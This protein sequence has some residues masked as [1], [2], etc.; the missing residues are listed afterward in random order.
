ML[1]YKF[2]KETYL[3]DS[4]PEADFPRLAKRAGEQLSQYKR[5]YTVESPEEDS[6]SLATCAIADAMYYF[7]V[8][9]NGGIVT[10][11]S[12][13]SVS[14][15]QQAQTIDVSQKAQAKEFY[16]CARLYLDIYRGCC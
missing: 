7:E 14:S 12:V 4:I 5:A 3:G 11:S 15:S 16:R 13:G 9:V 1:E 2:Y 8:A 6:E 10:S